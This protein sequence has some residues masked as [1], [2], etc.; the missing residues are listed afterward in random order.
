ME[1]QMRRIEVAEMH[2]HRVVTRY[3]MMDHECNEDIGEEVGI[4]DIST[5][6]K[7]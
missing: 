5:M 6:I 4:T 2:F 7:Y 3:R 1:K